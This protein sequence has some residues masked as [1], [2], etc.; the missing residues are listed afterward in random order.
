[1]IQP[2]KHRKEGSIPHPMARQLCNTSF[3]INICPLQFVPFVKQVEKICG[4]YDYLFV[5]QQLLVK[6]FSSFNLL[7]VFMQSI[8]EN[9]SQLLVGSLLSS[10]ALLLSKV[11]KTLIS[12]IWFECNQRVFDDK[13]SDRLD[14]FGPL[15]T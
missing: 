8:R 12:K 7:W 15:I 3:E 9:V 2:R 14:R 1:M 13:L 6:L 11:V 10:K 4:T 5:F